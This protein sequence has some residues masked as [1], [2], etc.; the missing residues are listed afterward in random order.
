M[1]GF[2]CDDCEKLFKPTESGPARIR[3]RR[4]AARKFLLDIS[5]VQENSVF[6]WNSIF[7]GK[8]RIQRIRVWGRNRMVHSASIV[9]TSCSLIILIVDLCDI[10]SSKVYLDD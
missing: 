1:Q 3:G 4:I 6:E 8:P 9:K 10:L 7:Q 5:F 2:Q